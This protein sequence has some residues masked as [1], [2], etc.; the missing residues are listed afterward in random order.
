MS[1]AVR[2]VPYASTVED[3][4]AYW[5]VGILWVL[6]A[7]AEQT[8]GEYSL[9]WELCPKGS[10]PP[11]H[12]HDQDEQFYLIDGE[13]TFR[14]GEQE[15]KVGSG[16]FVLVPRGTVHYFRV[17]SDTATILNSYTPGGF[18]RSITELGNPPRRAR[19]RPPTTSRPSLPASKKSRRFSTRSA[20]TSSTSRTCCALPSAP[21]HSYLNVEVVDAAGSHHVHGAGPAW[22]PCTS[23]SWPWRPCSPTCRT[24]PPTSTTPIARPRI[25]SVSHLGK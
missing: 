16:S 8:G 24:C 1:D 14:A 5:Q 17:D 4:P 7:T 18:E 23:T 10:G 25:A 20:C 9:M 12:Y 13:I 11:P 21:I 22:P 6:L 19:C 15:L 3:G 2:V